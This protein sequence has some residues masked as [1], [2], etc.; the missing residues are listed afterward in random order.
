MRNGSKRARGPRER[1]AGNNGQSE[2]GGRET[3]RS[4]LSKGFR[5]MEEEPAERDTDAGVM[6][7]AEKT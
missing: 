3:D 7:Q 2:A 1:P 5:I 6:K 4:L